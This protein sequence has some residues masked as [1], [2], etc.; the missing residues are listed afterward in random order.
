MCRLGEVDDNGTEN[1]LLTRLESMTMTDEEAM[2]ALSKR[3]DVRSGSDHRHK[4]ADHGQPPV[5]ATPLSATA[6]SLW[7]NHQK[8][9]GFPRTRTDQKRRWRNLPVCPV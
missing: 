3:Y 7:P 4:R 8:P 6:L 1:L 5:P 2:A 9:I